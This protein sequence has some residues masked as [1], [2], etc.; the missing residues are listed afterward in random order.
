MSAFRQHRLY[1]PHGF[2]MALEWKGPMTR[3]LY[4]EVE[5]ELSPVIDRARQSSTLIQDYKLATLT[6]T[7]YIQF[8]KIKYFPVLNMYTLLYL[9]NH[10]RLSPSRHYIFLSEIQFKVHSFFQQQNGASQ[11][12]IIIIIVY[13]IINL[14]KQILDWASKR[15]IFENKKNI[16]LYN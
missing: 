9:K 16:F 14:V 1:A 7:L 10:F 3:G 15:N 12:C 6:L 5:W 11:A 13:K 4:W 8:L 2:E